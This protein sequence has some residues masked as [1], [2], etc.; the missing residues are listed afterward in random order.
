MLLS[1]QAKDC[2]SEVLPNNLS[3]RDRDISMTLILGVHAQHWYGSRDKRVFQKFML[4]GPGHGCNLTSRVNK[5]E[6][7]LR[8]KKSRYNVMVTLVPGVVEHNS[9]SDSVRPGAVTANTPKR[10]LRDG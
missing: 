1:H 2:D 9:G 10:T 8:N 7:H 6:C 5:A 3:L 4:R